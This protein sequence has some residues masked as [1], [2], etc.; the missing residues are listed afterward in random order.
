MRASRS[1]PSVAAG[2]AAA[3]AA[4]TSTT[5][6]GKRKGKRRK[7]LKSRLATS[8]TERHWKTTLSASAMEELRVLAE[9]PLLRVESI[10][11]NLHRSLVRHIFEKQAAI[12][13]LLPNVSSLDALQRLKDAQDLLDKALERYQGGVDSLTQRTGISTAEQRRVQGGANQDS[14]EV[15]PCTC[16]H[17]QA[18]C[19]NPAFVFAG[20]RACSLTSGIWDADSAS[21][22]S[23]RAGATC[24]TA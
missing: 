8:A 23:Y 4:A 14:E 9:G 19:D 22:S 7:S 10:G 5:A 3:A 15:R 18:A 2:A 24:P 21:V 1:A 13:E 6:T 11:S 17:T 20:L 16:T 12:L